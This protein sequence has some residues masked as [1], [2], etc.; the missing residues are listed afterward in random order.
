M[1]VR[2][3]IKL[4]LALSF[5]AVIGLSA[6][7]A[8]LGLSNLS[9]MNNTETGIVAGP[10]QRMDLIHSMRADLLLEN[11]A[12][13]NVLLADNAQ[14]VARYEGEEKAA[15]EQLRRHHAQ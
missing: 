5:A 6:V 1:I 3:T 13:K 9:T 7:M 15:E 11:R 12:E 4:K 14:D 8:A 10:V 2:I